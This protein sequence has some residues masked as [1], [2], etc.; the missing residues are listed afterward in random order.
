VKLVSRSCRTNFALIPAS[1]RSIRR[2]L[3]CCTTQDWP[4]VAVRRRAAVPALARQSRPAAPDDVAMPAHDGGG[5]HD[6][7]HPGQSLD[8]QRP[9]S[10]ASHARSG[11]VKRE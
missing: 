1:S 2:F 8:G 3:A 7:P 5:S 6:Q 11:H 4:N 10:S 9:A